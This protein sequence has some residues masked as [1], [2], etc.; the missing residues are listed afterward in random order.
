MTAIPDTRSLRP[1]KYSRGTPLVKE[2]GVSVQQ[3]TDQGIVDCIVSVFNIVDSYGDVVVPGAFRDDLSEWKAKGDP[4]PFIWAHDWHNPFMIV[5]ETI[6]A[7]E[8]DIGLRVRAQLDIDTNATSAQVF[9]LLKSR[10]V[11]QFS[12]AFD[13]VEGG[14]AERFDPAQEKNIEVFEVR[15]LHLFEVGPWLVGVNRETQLLNT[16]DAVFQPQTGSGA[17]SSLED[18]KTSIPLGP[19]GSAMSPLPASGPSSNLTQFDGS[20]A[21]DEPAPETAG[22]ASSRPGIALAKALIPTMEEDPHD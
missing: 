20:H 9:K 15:Q 5:G 4:I 11:T 22:L 6:E 19:N 17:S 7:E 16:K 8:I 10:R 3:A 18:T 12:F 2:L 13:V 14:W 21:V 1:P